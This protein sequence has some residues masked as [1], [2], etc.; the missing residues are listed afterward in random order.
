MPTNPTNPSW[1]EPPPQRQGM[2]CAGKGCLLLAIVFGVVFLFLLISGYR[3]FSSGKQPTALPVKELPQEELADLN[4]RIDNFK[5]TSPVTPSFTPAPAPV[6]TTAEA[7]PTPTPAPSAPPGR[8]LIVTADQINGLISA[9][10]KSRGH[11]FVSL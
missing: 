6:T 8:E 2:G 7:S 10:P 11:A 5:N 9:N 3:F 4:Q 1:I